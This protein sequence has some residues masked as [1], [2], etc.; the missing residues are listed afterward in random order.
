MSEFADEIKSSINGTIRDSVDPNTIES[1][2]LSIKASHAGKVNKNY[3]F[4]TPRSMILGSETLLAPFSKHLQSLHNGDAVGVIREASYLDYA[5]EYDESFQEIAQKIEKATTPKELVE[6]VVA[7]TNHEFYSDKSYKGLGVAQVD[8]TLYDGKLIKDLTTGANSGKV[9]IGGN[10][11]EVYCSV[12]SKFMGS[13]HEHERG[14]VY[15]GQQCFAIYN[16]MKLDHIGFVPNPADTTTETVIVEDSYESEDSA[17]TI[18]D[19]KIQDNIQGNP[20]NMK[21]E[22]LKALLKS[23]EY[24]TKLVSDVTPE[25]KEKI[26]EYVSS[27]VKHLRASSYLLGT[28]KLLP[29]NTKENVAIALLAVE[30]LEDSPEKTVYL[31]ILENKK[32]SLF[33]DEEDASKVLSEFLKEEPATQEGDE[34]TEKTTQENVSGID[35]DEL[36]NKI[37][38]SLTEA[39]KEAVDNSPQKVEDSVQYTTM[40]TQ[41]S[42][43]ESDITALEQLN[44]QLTA[45]YKEATINQILMYKSLD[46]E[47][48][49][50]KQLET[51]APD[52]LE[53]LLTDLKLTNGKGT[54]S[55]P[56]KQEPE[57][58]NVKDSFEEKKE[59]QVASVAT[60][61][62]LSGGLSN[63]LKQNQSKI[64]K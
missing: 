39:Q 1:V 55:E 49:Y 35:L 14:K 42:Q 17:V 22:E 34:K 50:R 47:D 28:D 20:P 36:V 38:T 52:S 13:K 56:A 3:V 51:Y 32:K 27:T 54:K 63:F 43:L 46:D 31:D 24:V 23:N 21:L 12:C 18:E 64:N 44:E 48:A 10:S 58:V 33:E 8:A 15:E 4:Y 40:K 57:K 26:T 60:T 19:V 29:M 2:N 5:E 6:A 25:Q 11:R 9:S 59:N 62:R 53:I 41:N 7:L 61:N 30:L 16:N 37:V 45:K